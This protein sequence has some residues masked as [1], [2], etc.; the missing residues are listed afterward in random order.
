M[1][2]KEISDNTLVIPFPYS[3]E[4]AKKFLDD[5][6]IK[7]E[8]RGVQKNFAMR[9]SKGVLMGIIGIH[10][11]Y[12]LEADKSEFGYWLAKKYWNRGIMTAVVG[13]FCDLVKEKYKI[14]TLEAYVF[15]F[16][17]TS[18]RVLEKCSF[19]RTGGTI[20]YTKQDG[21]KVTGIGFEK[22]L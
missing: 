2:D 8:E 3:I 1:R 10:F 6:A 13:M 20:T 5:N 15:E 17:T 19:V 9:N 12:G 11:N 7:E 18:M 22:P 16:N 14:K 4:E 21:T